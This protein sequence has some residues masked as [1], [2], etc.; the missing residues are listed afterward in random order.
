VV[1]CLQS[2]A[3][4]TSFNSFEW[5]VVDND[6]KD[7]SKE[8]ILSQ[9]PQV[10]WID[11]GYNA[12]FARANNNGIRHATGDVVLLLNPDTI[13]LDDAIAQCYKAF[14]PSAY[15][16]GSVQLLNADK[17]PQIT[18]NFF[19]KGGLN[20]LLPLPYLGALLRSIAF[21][22]RVKKTNVQQAGNE[23]TVDWINGAFMMI[24]KVAIDKAGMFDEDFFLYSEE[25][26]WCSRLQKTGELCVYGNLH[27]IHL[28]GEVINDASKTTGKGYTNLFNRK[29]LQILVSQHVRIRKQFGVA[30]FLFHLAVHTFEIPVYFI[31]SFL[32]N[33][34]HLRN[35]FADIANIAGF[36]SNVFRLWELVPVIISNAP[37]FY[38][39]L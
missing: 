22:A 17:S 16:A 34:F 19:M 30:W 29:G 11:M 1:D 9:F 2:A 7:N 18:G 13:I 28:Q 39:V 24:K 12:G 37:H 20:H 32:D 5:I 3:Q 25:I 27:I 10:H 26:E 23:Q 21:T 6:S 33:L 4:F 36:T 15:I 14:I 31:C 8:A 35:P 38:K